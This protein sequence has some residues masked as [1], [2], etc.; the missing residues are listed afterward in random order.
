MERPNPSVSVMYRMAI[1]KLIGA[2]AKNLIQQSHK[3]HAPKNVLGTPR[4]RT[5]REKRKFH[6]ILKRR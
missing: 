5:S 4:K 2:P 1:A 6:R 3:I